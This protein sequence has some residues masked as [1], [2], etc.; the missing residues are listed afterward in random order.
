MKIVISLI[1]L[2]KRGGHK[3]RN[4]SKTYPKMA[5]SIYGFQHGISIIDLVKTKAEM[6][7]SL[8]FIQQLAQENKQILLVGTSKHV[9]ELVIQASGKMGSGMPYVAERWLGGTLSNWD[10]I[11]KTLKTLSRLK[12]LKSN[13]E[14]FQSLKKKERLSIDRRIQKL[15]LVFGGL[16]IL[17]NNKPA[18]IIVL[19][20]T[21][22][23]LAVKEAGKIP[24]IALV[25]MNENPTGVDYVIPANTSSKSLI[26]FFLDK[27][28]ESYNNGLEL[29]AKDI[30]TKENSKES[31]N[32]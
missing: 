32:A 21:K 17:K 29:R 15:E 25:N 14:E 7:L 31:A 3:G 13:I 2:F 4:R 1:D 12:N 27:V 9:S 6:E 5:G 28:V 11:R 30:E 18:A 19:D 20:T 23:D 22:D 16:A 24:V 10:T 26:A 8:D